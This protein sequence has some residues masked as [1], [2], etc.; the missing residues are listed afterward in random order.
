MK[1]I[2]RTSSNGNA[3]ITLYTDGTRIVEYP[4]SGLVLD[5]P[6]NVDIRLSTKCAFGRNSNTGKAVCEF[7]HESATTNGRVANYNELFLKLEGLP[8]TTELAIGANF[9][10]REFTLFMR[11]LRDAE[12][13]TNITINQGMLNENKDNLEHLIM[14]K[15][16]RGV[17]ISFRSSKWSFHD[18][19]RYSNVVV[20]VIA[21]IDDWDDVNALADAG[22]KKI[23]ILG[24]K[25]FGFNA[26]KVD[27]NSESHKKWF[28]NLSALFKRFK[29]I[30]FDNLALE[31]LNV[32]RFYSDQD[33][34]VFNQG[35]H[36]IYINAVDKYFAPSSRSSAIESWDDQT[37]QSYFKKV[38]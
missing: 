32:R 26:G 10:D 16:V 1:S 4:D 6:M 7:C 20:H 24:E 2:L 31:Q 9:I 12:F 35:E 34:S 19:Q 21:G 22:V 27:L 36:S 15:Y 18:L 5:Y 30:S 37:V 11:K 14:A 38:K 25:D 28:R 29:V 13:I 33:W 3:S 23:L 8:R 17:G